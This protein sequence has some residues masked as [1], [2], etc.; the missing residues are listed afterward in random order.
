MKTDPERTAFPAGEPGVGP[1]LFQGTGTGRLIAATLL[2]SLPSL[3]GCTALITFEEQEV[4]KCDD[5][6]GVDPCPAELNLECVSGICQRIQP[7]PPEIPCDPVTVGRDPCPR[8][9]GLHCVN[10][11][12]VECASEPEKCNGIDDDCNGEVD[13]GY[14]EDG[15][16]FTW[17]GGGVEA[18]RDCGPD[19][20]AIHPADP[21]RGVLAATEVCDGKDNDCNGEIDEI[22][23]CIENIPGYDPD[24]PSTWECDPADPDSCGAYL[25]CDPTTLRCVAPLQ[26]GSFCNNDSACG[27]AIC[28]DP[29]ALNLERELG[30]QKICAQACCTDA[31]CEQGNVCLIPGTGARVCVPASFAGLETKRAGEACRNSEQCSSG[32]CSQRTCQTA[33]ASDDDCGDLSCIFDPAFSFLSYVGN[34][35]QFVCGEEQGLGEPGSICVAAS[36][37]R[38]GLCTAAVCTIPCGSNADCEPYD[39]V[40]DYHATQ[41]ITGISLIPG[42]RVS[43]CYIP[44][45]DDPSTQPS[46]ELCCKDEH[47]G[48]GTRC[49]PD[50]RRDAWGMYCMAEIL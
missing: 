30:G 34:P 23:E 19:D 49:R 41:A 38:S 26:L 31:D 36:N 21:S 20:P 42:T 25:K 15:D 18:L 14:D 7:E 46:G 12:C 10:G 11:V 5:S 27:D 33:C 29:A 6:N 35:G 8:G 45:P 43:Y 37:C 24:D 39:A 48:P 40:C 50:M 17:C 4:L 22:P 2:L 47:C 9:E 13:E 28:V 44:L 32:I 16:G 1:A 3:G